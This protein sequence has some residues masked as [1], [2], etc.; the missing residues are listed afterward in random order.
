MNENI[1]LIV[2]NR[3]GVILEEDISGVS[4]KNKKGKFDVLTNHA[5][6]ISIIEGALIIHQK[7]G[8][9][10]EMAVDNGIIKVRENTIE[11][12]LGIKK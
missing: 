5:N 8:R 12:Y 4:S 7:D 6:F 3:D 1:H 2:I 11:V 10:K 9:E